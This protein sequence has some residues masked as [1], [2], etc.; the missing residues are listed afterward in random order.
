[1]IHFRIWIFYM[2]SYGTASHS[3][4]EVVSLGSINFDQRIMMFS[5]TTVVCICVCL[6]TVSTAVQ[7]NSWRKWMDDKGTLSV[8]RF[9]R[10]LKFCLAHGHA[11]SFRGSATA[12]STRLLALKQTDRGDMMQPSLCICELSENPT[13]PLQ[14]REA[15]G[16]MGTTSMV[17]RTRKPGAGQR[18]AATAHSGGDRI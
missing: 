2:T 3:H 5:F 4:K 13:S 9:G 16:G 7:P 11:T 14:K 10:R 17:F 1:M 8:S 18:S 12:S 6:S 15:R